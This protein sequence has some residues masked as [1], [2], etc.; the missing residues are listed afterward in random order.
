MYE[1]LNKEDSEKLFKV[2]KS[3]AAIIEKFGDFENHSKVISMIIK[4][5][6]LQILLGKVFINVVK[7][8]FL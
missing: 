6:Q 7:G 3:N 4:D 2:L 8:C 5:P 1:K